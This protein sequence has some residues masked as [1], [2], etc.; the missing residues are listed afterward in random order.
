MGTGTLNS[1]DWGW[2]KAQ[3]CQPQTSPN[4]QLVPPEIKKKLAWTL[5]VLTFMKL[6]RQI[7]QRLFGA[8]V[9]IDGKEVLPRND[10]QRTPFGTGKCW[11]TRVFWTHNWHSTFLY[12]MYWHHLTRRI[13]CKIACVIQWLHHGCN[14]NAIESHSLDVIQLVYDTCMGRAPMGSRRHKI[15]VETFRNSHLE[16]CHC[17]KHPHFQP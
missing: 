13:L 17:T 4:C 10:P 1:W 5:P 3:N 9:W 7:F 6:C 15:A 14:P 12:D 11:P 8:Q 2:Q 16:G